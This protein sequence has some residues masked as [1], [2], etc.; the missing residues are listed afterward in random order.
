MEKINT[1]ADKK[2]TTTT[3]YVQRNKNINNAHYFHKYDKLFSDLSLQRRH[4][5]S[6]YDTLVHIL[7]IIKCMT[8]S[9]L[10][11]RMCFRNFP[12]FYFPK[13]FTFDA[14][15]FPNW[16]LWCGKQMQK[17]TISSS[18]NWLC[19]NIKTI[20]EC[21]HLWGYFQL[22]FILTYRLKLPS[23]MCF[24]KWTSKERTKFIW[25]LQLEH[26]EIV[27]YLFHWLISSKTI[28]L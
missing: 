12:R 14:T 8:T 24:E 1:T 7:H 3:N 26:A 23:S 27:L 19:P 10:H 21:T 11:F 5:E 13:P 2:T 6:V 18:S 17:N 20:I 28:F 25:L 9:T 16:A 4:H 15:I 22:I